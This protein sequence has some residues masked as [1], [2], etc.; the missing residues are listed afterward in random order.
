MDIFEFYCI[1]KSTAYFCATPPF[2]DQPQPNTNGVNPSAAQQGRH[3]P[4]LVV[5][6]GLGEAAVLHEGQVPPPVGHVSLYHQ[7]HQ[8]RQQVVCGQRCSVCCKKEQV[9]LVSVKA[10]HHPYYV[11]PSRD[12]VAPVGVGGLPPQRHVHDSISHLG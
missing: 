1:R 3:L 7:I 4:E 12:N 10:E 8:D 11:V 9:R 5:V 2:L 6:A